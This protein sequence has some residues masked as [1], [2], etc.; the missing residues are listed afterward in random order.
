[1]ANEPNKSER[2][3]NSPGG[4]DASELPPAAGPHARLELTDYEKTP[5]AGSLPD[6][7]EGGEADVGSE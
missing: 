4:K 1:M 2:E 7:R 5:G 3:N 6:R